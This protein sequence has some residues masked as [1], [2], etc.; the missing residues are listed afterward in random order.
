VADFIVVFPFD[1]L[2]VRYLFDMDVRIV[3][4]NEIVVNKLL[5]IESVDCAG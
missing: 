3:L 5:D 4:V 1:G 2:I